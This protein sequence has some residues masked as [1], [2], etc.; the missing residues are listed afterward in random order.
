MGKIKTTL[1]DAKVRDITFFEEDISELTNQLTMNEALYKDFYGVYKDLTGGRYTNIKSPRDIAEI[2]KA[3]VQLRSLCSDTTFKRHQVRKNL[4]D[5]V[6][7]SGD[8]IAD[9]ENL[10]KET[11]R[12]IINEV[13]NNDY[14]SRLKESN[15]LSQTVN[16]EVKKK[17]DDKVK[18]FISNGDIKL[19]TNDKLIGVNDHIQYK[20][21]KKHDNFIA[22]DERNGR[23]I[24]NF[25]KERLPD[26]KIVRINKD[27]IITTSGDSYEIYGEN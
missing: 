6:Y 12:I 3:L 23:I 15:K 20:Y 11:A 13:R 8:E 14:E 4:S 18:K 25:P 22:V 9:K 17:L 1:T 10:I 2:A 16:D 27:K 19:S 7:R 26:T 5:I 24:T 21:D